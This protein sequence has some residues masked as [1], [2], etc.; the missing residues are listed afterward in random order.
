[1]EQR[2]KDLLFETLQFLRRVTEKSFIDWK[3]RGHGD[4]FY[5]GSVRG[6][7]TNTKI[8]YLYRYASIYKERDNAKMRL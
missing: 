2:S 3:D 6:C 5:T 1:M 7:G 4:Y 8:E